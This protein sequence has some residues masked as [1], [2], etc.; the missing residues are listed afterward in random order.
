MAGVLLGGAAVTTLTG[1]RVGLE[2]DAVTIP[3]PP[4]AD[5]LARGRAAQ[6]AERLLSLLQDVRLL[7]PDAAVVL[8]RIASQHEAHIA[9]LRLP[10]TTTTTTPSPKARPTGGLPTGTATG[11]ALTKQTALLALAGGQEAAAARVRAD[12]ADVS[13]DLARLLAAIGASR[14]CH[15]DAV[16]AYD[17]ARTT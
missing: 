12:L 5:E 1:C 9:A 13:G 2:Q 4:T 3:P 17:R 7:R 8:G 11:P 14:D 16:R 6:D 15:A 10:T